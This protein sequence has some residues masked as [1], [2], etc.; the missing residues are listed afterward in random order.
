MVLRYHRLAAIT[1][2]CML[3]ALVLP[4]FSI[5]LGEPVPDALAVSGPAQAG[6]EA[7]ERAG[8]DSGVL[9]PTEVLVGTSDPHPFAY[10]LAA[11]PGVRTAVAPDG[12]ARRDQSCRRLG[13][14][15]RQL[16]H[17]RP[18]T[19]RGSSGRG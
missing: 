13:Q 16:K 12:E 11:V 14:R 4:V 19:R 3:G 15:E 7:L 5:K 1:A 2:L 9:R 17:R 18:S 10:R 6:L 8:I